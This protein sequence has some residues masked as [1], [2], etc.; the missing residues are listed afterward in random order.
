[1]VGPAL[2]FKDYMDTVHE[3]LFRGQ[4]EKGNS[5]RIPHGRKRVAYRKLLTGLAFLGLYVVLG[6]SYNFAATLTSDFEKMNWFHRY[7]FLSFL[8]PALR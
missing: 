8:S 3:T 1:L 4:E 2:E 7:G 6:G 5:R